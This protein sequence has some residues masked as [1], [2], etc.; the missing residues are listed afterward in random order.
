MKARV[1]TTLIYY[2]NKLHY[3]EMIYHKKFGNMIILRYQNLSF[4]LFSLSENY[5]EVYI[6]W[7]IWLK[8]VRILTLY[9][10]SLIHALDQ[11]LNHVTSFWRKIKNIRVSRKN[12]R[13]QQS[14]RIM[15]KFQTVSMTLWAVHHTRLVS[16]LCLTSLRDLDARSLFPRG[17][18][19]LM[20]FE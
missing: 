6:K 2:V 4:S 13:R 1:A 11:F 7:V 9:F 20:L 16:F 12:F 10:K 19:F 5:I 8:F 18:S 3:F 15:E 17:T 14:G